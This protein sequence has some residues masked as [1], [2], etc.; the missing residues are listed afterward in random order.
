MNFEGIQKEENI[1]DNDSKHE[2]LFLKNRLQMELISRRVGM[3]DD[4]DILI[5]KWIEDE[6]EKFAEIFDEK[7]KENP[8]FIDSLHDIPSEIIEEFEE[9][10]YGGLEEAA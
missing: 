5:N 8:N 3:D 4:S 10:L 9:K 7:Y 2:R 1:E 6:S